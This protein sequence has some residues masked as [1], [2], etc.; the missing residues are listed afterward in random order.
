MDRRAASGLLLPPRLSESIYGARPYNQPWLYP[1]LGRIV[2]VADSLRL[3]DRVVGAEDQSLRPGGTLQLARGHGRRENIAA[4]LAREVDPARAGWHW[5]EY[6]LKG[7][8]LT[9][10]LSYADVAAGYSGF[11][12]WGDLLSIG[13]ERSLVGSTR[14]SAGS[15]RSASSRSRPT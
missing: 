12:F 4:V 10:V 3:S 1:F 6:G 15:S 9:G 11:A 7:R 5:T 8:S 14:R 2:L 13:R